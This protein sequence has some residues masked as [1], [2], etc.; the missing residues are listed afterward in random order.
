[1]KKRKK[2]VSADLWDVVVPPL[3]L[4]LLQLDGDSSDWAALDALHQVCHIPER[5][6]GAHYY[7]SYYYY[8][9]KITK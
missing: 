1:M 8:I 6:T 5:Q 4:L 2:G 3:S 7:Y 9:I